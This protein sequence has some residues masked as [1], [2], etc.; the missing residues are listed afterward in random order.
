M[1]Y[2]LCHRQV[3]SSTQTSWTTRT[4]GK[5]WW[6]TASPG[7]FTTAPSS[8]PLERLTWPWHALSTSPVSKSVTKDSCHHRIISKVPFKCGVLTIWCCLFLR[9]SQ[10]LGHCGRA[11]LASLCPEHNRRLRSH[12]SPQP[13]ARPLCAEAS[14]HLRCLQ[15]PRRAD[16]RG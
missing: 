1:F 8:A 2:P 14:H 7:W 5:L 12:L 6:T 16:G 15:S 4:C 11:R 3:P 10:H 9:A 13:Y